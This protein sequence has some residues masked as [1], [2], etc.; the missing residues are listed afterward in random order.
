MKMWFGAD[1]A[2][3]ADIKERFL[4]DL[5]LVSTNAGGAFDALTLDSHV[6]I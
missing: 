6:S 5:E 4:D 1:P 3:D 2:V